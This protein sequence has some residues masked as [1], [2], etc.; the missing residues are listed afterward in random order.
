MFKKPEEP[1]K[2]HSDPLASATDKIESVSSGQTLS[3]DID[4]VSFNELYGKY[5]ARRKA[6][7]LVFSFDCDNQVMKVSCPASDPEPAPEPEAAPE[8]EPE[9]DQ[10]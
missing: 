7:E 2:L 5:T 1:Q 9:E 8:P 3:I 6:G 10:E 4:G